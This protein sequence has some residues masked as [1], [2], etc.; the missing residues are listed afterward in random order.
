MYWHHQVT[1]RTILLYNLQISLSSA[2]Q[3]LHFSYQFDPRSLVHKPVFASILPCLPLSHLLH[4]FQATL[5]YIA[6]LP[7][8]R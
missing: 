7:T 4:R 3:Q 8:E 1:S 5:L 2:D 6:A